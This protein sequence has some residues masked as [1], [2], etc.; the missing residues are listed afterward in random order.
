MS[1]DRKRKFDANKEDTPQKRPTE[2]TRCK[3]A[4]EDPLMLEYHDKE[5]GVAIFDDQK[6]FELLTLEGA[7]AGL[8]WKTILHKRE[9]YRIAFD[10]FNID[11]IAKYQQNK[12]DDLLQDKGIVRNKLKV[13][14]VVKNAQAVQQIQK[15]FGSFSDFIWQYVQ[16]Q[17]ETEEHEVS[18]QKEDEE[19]ITGKKRGRKSSSSSSSSSSPH[20]PSSSFPVPSP[21]SNAYLPSTSPLSNN[22][23]KELKKRG[24][25]FVGSTI[26]QSFLQAG[27]MINGHVGVC[28]MR[29]RGEGTGKEKDKVKDEGRGE[30]RR[31]KRRKKE[32]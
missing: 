19:E 17:K 25:G 7:Q 15:E 23:S 6:L 9:N 24:F 29:E 10:Y 18:N 22:L 2:K 30:T 5:W 27:G 1:V 31:E 8:S 3:W 16:K 11:K 14:S 12:I 21:S 26:V 28:E 4:L 32:S 13:R 20:P